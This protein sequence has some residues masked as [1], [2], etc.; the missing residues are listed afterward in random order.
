MREMYKIN[1]S[2]RWNTNDMSIS[3]FARIVFPNILGQIKKAQDRVLWRGVGGG[4]GLC[5][6]QPSG[7]GGLSLDF[8]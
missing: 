1:G 2:M 5:T 6:V 3:W 7:G 8:G 4:V